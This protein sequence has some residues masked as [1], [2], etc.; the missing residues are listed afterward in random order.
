ME[1][2]LI[3][4]P[5]QFFEE[6]SRHSCPLLS[7]CNRLQ[8]L[9]KYTPNLKKLLWSSLI[10]LILILFSYNFELNQL[11]YWVDGLTQEKSTCGECAL[12]F[13]LFPAISAVAFIA[14]MHGL[15]GSLF[16]GRACETGYVIQ[17]YLYLGFEAAF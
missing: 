7:A 10:V 2:Q 5:S 4:T 12:V 16:N 17:K 11:S 6:H 8:F 1:L 3:S 14:A 9:L 15:T 13:S